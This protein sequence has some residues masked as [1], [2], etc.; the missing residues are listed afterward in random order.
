MLNHTTTN[1][2]AAATTDV[3]ATSKMGDITITTTTPLI[4]KTSLPPAAN[5]TTNNSGSTTNNNNNKTRLNGSIY[6]PLSTATPLSSKTEDT[7]SAKTTTPLNKSIKHD[8]FP[9]VTFC[10]LSSEDLTERNTSSR[11]LKNSV[12]NISDTNGGALNGS[13]LAN[14]NNVKKRKRLISNESG[15]SIESGLSEKK[16]PEMPDGGYGWVVVF[17][18]LVVSLIADGLS[19]SFGLINTEL[20]DYFGESPSKTA[21][22]SSLF[23]SVPLL[24]GPIWSNLVDKYGC[25]KMTII[26]GL[27][28]AIGF[29]LSSI[30]NSVEM[31]MVTFGIIS[32]LGLGIGYVTAVVSIAFWFDK[33]RTFATGIGASGTGIGT[34]LYAPLTQLLI[35]NYGW[36]GATLILAGTMLNACVCGALMR[37]PD[38]LIEENRLES[39]SQSVTTFSNSSVCLEEIKKL[40]DTGATK[41]YVLDTLVTKNNTEANQQIDD[42]H[43]GHMKKYR[44]E[45]FLPT[46]LGSQDLDLDLY[47]VKSMSRRSLRHKEGAEAPSR[48]NLL[49]MSSAGNPYMNTT[50]AVIGS[51][52]DTMMGGIPSEVAENAKRHILASIETLSPSEKRS[53]NDIPR[54]PMNTSLASLRSSTD[55]GYLTQKYSREHNN[56]SVDHYAISRY[57]LNENIFFAAKNISASYK[58]LRVNGYRHNSV[59]IL[60]PEVH[61]YFSCAKDEGNAAAAALIEANLRKH[62]ELSGIG[63]GPAIIQ[64]PENETLLSGGEQQQTNKT[65]LKR[66][67]TDSITGMRR[68]SK[69]RKPTY[70]SNLRR[71]ISIRNSNF[72]KDMRVHR[73]SINYRGAML[74]THRYRLRA[75]SCPNIYRNSMTTIAKEDEDTWY[76]NLID[77]MKSVFDFSLFKD[78]KFTLFNLSTLF[79][80]IWFIIPYLYLPE[81]MRKYDYDANDSAR[82]ISAIGV[83]QTIGMIGLGYIGDCSWMN[84]NVCYSGCMLICGLSVVLMPLVV[85]SYNLLLTLC[86]IF[87]FTFASSFSFTPSIL[88]SI[89]DL[90][91]FTCAYGLVLLVQGVGMIAGPPIAGA[92]FE[93]TLRWDDTFYFAGVFIALSGISS[94][95]IEFCEKKV[96][97][98]DSD[99]SELKKINLI[100]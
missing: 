71:N 97:E 15:D 5:C 51:P 94:Y 55:E 45:L 56:H 22:I 96:K 100:H 48:E 41:E 32:G 58:D 33:K 82:L 17:A 70:R 29:G 60:N 87:G 18:S 40:L 83:A 69:S 10:N 68:L 14:G 66:T 36:R 49:S 26:G 73:T 8:L 88:V 62:N 42:P 7:I 77:T 67:R 19:F 38:W 59:D 95:L 31:L 89:V 52:D 11:L 72:L 50:A 20:L 98:S 23:F 37:D 53:S 78:I 99:V 76:D 92:I 12:I 35:D 46:F 65:L 1:A 74:N 47:E 30:C 27:V 61:S 16:K 28:S 54:T 25:R 80:F 2:D 4:T 43:E 9:E 3:D 85:T 24:M 84:V 90:D 86:I 63:G 44:S 39:R 93:A 6:Q 64:I 21:W 91:D 75:S 81:F 57:S 34:F 79:L 13:S